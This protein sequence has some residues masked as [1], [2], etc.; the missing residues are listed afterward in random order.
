MPIYKQFDVVVV[1]FPSK[2]RFKLFT[3]NNQLIIKKIGSL[4]IRDR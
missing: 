3:L 1:P 4:S 2:I